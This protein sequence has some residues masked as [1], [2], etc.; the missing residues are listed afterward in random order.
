MRISD[1]SSDVC[2]SDLDDAYP[3]DRRAPAADEQAAALSLGLVPLDLREGHLH[4]GFQRLEFAGLRHL[5]HAYLGLGGL[6]RIGPHLVDDITASFPDGCASVTP[7]PR[8]LFG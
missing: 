3:S 4:V 6:G 8:Q 2:S 1:W 5:Q 7:P